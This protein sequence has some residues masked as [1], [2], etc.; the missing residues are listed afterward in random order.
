ML[1]E[2]NSWGCG[3]N[4][5]QVLSF[6]LLFLSL[7]YFVCFYSF[8]RS[9]KVFWFTATYQQSLFR[10]W[11]RSMNFPLGFISTEESNAWNAKTV[12]Y[13]FMQAFYFYH[14]SLALLSS[15][16]PTY[17]HLFPPTIT[18]SLTSTSFCLFPLFLPSLFLSLSS[19]S[20]QTLRSSDHPSSF[21]LSEVIFTVVS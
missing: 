12:F 14:E 2:L 10:R 15:S 19:L 8:C 16:L 6:F 13:L 11:S 20:Q 17:F 9:N 18:I 3:F 5:R 1:I 4:Y 21:H 7:I